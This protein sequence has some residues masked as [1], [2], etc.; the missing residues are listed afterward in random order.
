MRRAF[1]M[2][3]ITFGFVRRVGAE[4]L[5]GGTSQPSPKGYGGQAKSR[6]ITPIHAERGS[7]SSRPQWGNGGSPNRFPCKLVFRLSCHHLLPNVPPRRE[8]QGCKKTTFSSCN[9]TV[10]PGTT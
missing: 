3:W 9:N 10:G 5:V 7:W 2:A 6:V 8:I 1:S 4:H